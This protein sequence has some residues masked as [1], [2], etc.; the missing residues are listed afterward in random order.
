MKGFLYIDDD[1]LGEADFKIIDE[2]MGVIGGDFVPNGNYNKYRPI[3]Q[4]QC[5]QNGISN[6]TDFHYRIVLADNTELNPAGGI[7]IT[8]FE[9]FDEIYVESAGLDQKAIE[10]CR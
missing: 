6:V 1:L 2:S 7:G 3:I 9:E 5:D 10:K 4:K 8:D